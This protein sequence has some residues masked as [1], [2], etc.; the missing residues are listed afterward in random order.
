LKGF[1]HPGVV[2]ILDFDN[3]GPQMRGR[4]QW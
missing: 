2:E 1:E 4:I 3:F